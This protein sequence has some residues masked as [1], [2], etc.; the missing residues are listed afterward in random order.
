V[1]NAAQ[2]AA[3]DS[4]TCAR[5][6][7]LLDY[8][9]RGCVP[10]VKQQ[11]IAMSLN[12]SEVRDTARVGRISTYQVLSELKKKEGMRIQRLVRTTIC[13]SKLTQL[14]DIII[15]LFVNCSACG[16]AV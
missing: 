4:A 7:L 1:S 6:R 14:H 12:T 9:N 15:G 11:I 16:R 13:F 10:A 8:R 5:G 2:H 3:A